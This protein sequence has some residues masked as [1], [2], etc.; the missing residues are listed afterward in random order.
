MGRKS[1][2]FPLPH[3]LFTEKG[4]TW[5]F[6]IRKPF[7]EIVCLVKD[8]YVLLGTLHIWHMHKALPWRAGYSKIVKSCDCTNGS[9]LQSCLSPRCHLGVLRTAETG[10][11]GLTQTT[12]KYCGCYESLSFW[13]WLKGR[14]QAHLRSSMGRFVSFPVLRWQGY[15]MRRL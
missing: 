11:W 9:A 3:S 12:S 4:F 14:L 6:G 2:C 5:G 15:W 8:F 13:S 10:G 7:F 1:H